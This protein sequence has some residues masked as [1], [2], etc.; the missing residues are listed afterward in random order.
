MVKTMVS[1]ILGF[2]LVLLFLFSCS[3]FN[4][5]AYKMIEDKDLHGFNEEIKDMTS[6]QI[7]SKNSDGVWLL[8]K[9]VTENNIPV[10]ESLLK[11]SNG[12]FE[13]VELLLN[14]GAELDDYTEYETTALNFSVIK[15]HW[16]V[17][18]LLINKDA[19]VNIQ[20]SD[21]TS[22]LH[23]ASAKDGGGRTPLHHATYFSHVDVVE[24]LLQNNAN[25]NIKSNS[26]QYE[27]P[28]LIAKI[29][30]ATAKETNDSEKLE[31]LRNIIELLEAHGAENYEAEFKKQ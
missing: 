5:V 22:A 6:S 9:A 30:E 12:H 8:K 1:K 7:D 25:P 2:L 18:E 4:P 24:L 31:K 26:K 14:E 16:D 23:A 15:G 11:A 21:K 27:T 13:I 20:T 3:S 17:A 10:I 28:L 19:N 29:F